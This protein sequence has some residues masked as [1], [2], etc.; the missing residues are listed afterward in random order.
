MIG[1]RKLTIIW[2]VTLWY[3][4]FFCILAIIMTTFTYL[5]SD[6]IMEKSVKD[7]LIHMVDEAA[8]EIEYEDGVL[9]VDDEIDFLDQG[10]YLSIYDRDNEMLLGLLP[11]NYNPKKS[12]SSD[13]I[14][15]IIITGADWYIYEKITH[16]SDY[17]TVLIRGMV[18]SGN[19]GSQTISTRVLLFVSPIII[20]IAIIGGYRLTRRA[21][22]PIHQMR[23]TVEQISSGKDL[24]KRIGLGKGE[25]EL[26]KL[27][28]QF[29]Q[30]FERLDEAFEREKQFTSD[31]SHELR[32]P[33]SVILSQCEYAMEQKNNKETKEALE[34]IY[35][36]TSR[37]SNMIG[38]LLTLARSDGGRER[39]SLEE[40]FISELVEV[41]VE[42]LREKAERK[43][44]R[45]EMEVEEE[46]VL[47]GDEMMLIRFFTNLISN[48]IHYGRRGGWIKVVLKRE[49]DKIK[50]FVQDNGIG[51]AKEEQDKIFRRFY[52]VDSARTSKEESNSGLG[53]AM[54]RWIA[55][56]HQGEVTVE[57]EEGIG[58]TFP[59]WFPIYPI[60]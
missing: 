2:K 52:Q 59:F 15:K 9:E 38:Q 28:E 6:K 24:T 50:G 3:T 1:K 43:Q 58:S 56:A 20:L 37:M 21:F 17:G 7:H 42:E 14:K 29:D 26:Y 46:L 55:T 54:V 36:Q 39:L 34:S 40:I 49:E 5:V 25:D 8:D 12:I 23:R 18:E 51:I 41:I 10:V 53:L 31:V 4:I 45:I 47:Y 19:G 48:A 22:R 33:V 44:I 16:V 57:S 27:A 60:K 11:K 35:H 13:G 32:T 30:M